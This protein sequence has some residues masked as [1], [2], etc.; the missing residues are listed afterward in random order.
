MIGRKSENFKKIIE[1]LNVISKDSNSPK[2]ID[3]IL[4]ENN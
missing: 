1:G 3:N 4:T 2:K